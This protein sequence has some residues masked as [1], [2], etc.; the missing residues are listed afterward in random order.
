MKK[1]ALSA[2][3]ALSTFG[4]SA[5]HAS[6][7]LTGFYVGGSIGYAVATNTVEDSDCWYDCSA[8]TVKPDSLSFGIQGGQN[9]ASGNLLFGW[10]ADYVVADMDDQINYGDGDM[11]VQSEAKSM[12]SL[13]AKAGLAVGNTAVIASFGPAQAE[14]DSRMVATYGSTNP[15]TWYTAKFDDTASGIV[16]GIG[17]E[18]AVSDKLIVAADYSKYSF[19]T[20]Q[21]EFFY[22]DGSPQTDR[23]NLVHSLENFRVSASYKF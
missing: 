12:L 21:A 6:D 3:I 7:A 14:F 8:Y 2:A 16:F 17:L 13:R 4:F 19:D 11:R 15:A 1:L 22:A 20:E 5:A 18:H 23:V 10:M 9:V